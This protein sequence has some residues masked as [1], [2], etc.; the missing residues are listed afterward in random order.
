M[1]GSITIIRGGGQNAKHYFDTEVPESVEVANEVWK[2]EV[3]G[4][5]GSMA[6]DSKS[7]EQIA[8]KD[9]NPTEHPEVIITHQFMGG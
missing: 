5:R 2:N 8:K 9:F 7:K 1:T 6:F 4:A 3:R